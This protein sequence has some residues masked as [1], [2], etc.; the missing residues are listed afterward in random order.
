ME[1]KLLDTIGW[2]IIGELQRDARISFSELGRRVGLSTPAAAERVRRLEAAGIIGGYEARIDPA[3]VGY[4][5]SA[6]VRI[7]VASDERTA[8]RLAAAVTQMPEVRECHRVTGDCAFLLRADL[9]TVGQLEAL[10]DRLTSFGMTST[11]IVLSSPLPRRP[12]SG[13]GAA[14]KERPAAFSG[15][16]GRT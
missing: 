5:I 9:A 1:S 15:R 7:T 4:P 6:F 16:R 2:K 8:R 10:I 13:P 14:A 3:A 12:L 11:S